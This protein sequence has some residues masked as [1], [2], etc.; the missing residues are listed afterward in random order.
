[1]KVIYGDST[2]R[3]EIAYMAE[4]KNIPEEIQFVRN[5]GFWITSLRAMRSI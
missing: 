3:L 1:M 5:K 2:D 4:Q